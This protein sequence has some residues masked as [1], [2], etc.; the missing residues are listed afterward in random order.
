MVRVFLD[1][2]GS[3][4]QAAARLHPCTTTLHLHKNTVHYRVRKAEEPRGRPGHVGVALRV[5]ALLWRRLPSASVRS[6]DGPARSQ[7]ARTAAGKSSAPRAG[8]CP[9]R[10]PPPRGEASGEDTLSLGTSFGTSGRGAETE[11]MAGESAVESSR[12]GSWRGGRG[13]R[14]ATVT[15]ARAASRLPG[16]S[17]VWTPIR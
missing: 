3:Y 13:G 15:Q 17:G 14:P 16:G 9:S 4:V 1:C 2:D 12:L 11:R 10:A 6:R 8:C 5:T 7:P